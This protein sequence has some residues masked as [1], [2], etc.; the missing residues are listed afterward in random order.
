VVSNSQY[1]KEEPS[2]IKAIWPVFDLFEFSSRIEFEDNLLHIFNKILNAEPLLAR[3]H[4]QFM[5]HFPAIHEK[6]GGFGELTE[7]VR[8]FLTKG[9]EYLLGEE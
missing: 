3:P 6:Q 8:L 1:L 4:F 2:L 7:T 5:H 9:R